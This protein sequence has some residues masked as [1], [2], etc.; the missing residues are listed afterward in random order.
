MHGTFKNT[1]IPLLAILLC[2]LLGKAQTK[3]F[4]HMDVSFTAGSMGVGLDVATPLCDFM[5]IRTGFT[6]MPKLTLNSDFRVE[7]GDGSP[8]SESGIQK[9]SDMMDKTLHLKVD[10]SVAMD[11]KPHFAQFKLMLDFLPFRNNKHWKFTA[12]FFVGGSRI[13][14]AVNAIEDAPTLLGVTSYNYFYVQSCRQES[15]FEGIE[16]GGVQLPDVELDKHYLE[17][18][19]LGIPLGTFH[20]GKKAMLVPDEYGSVR[21]QMRVNR[22]RP[23]LGCGYSTALSKDHSW[24]FSVEA[25]VMFWG[26]KPKVYV[27]NVYKI[28]VDAIDIDDYRYDIVRPNEDGSDF[29]VD[30]PLDHVD[31]VG[32]LEGINGKVGDMVRLVSRFK[33]YPNLSISLAYRIP[34]SS[35]S[36][37]R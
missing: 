21:A 4:Q 3:P 14:D 22:F 28:D 16:M 9:I 32:D 24:H 17:K 37:R 7:T 15:I 31:L 36:S 12:G 18:G 19:M 11:M 8:V 5:Q 33:C 29:V 13:G 35:G 26:G 20:D 1:A 27:D 10:E 2:P 25:G 6:Y 23:Y 30:E 34:F